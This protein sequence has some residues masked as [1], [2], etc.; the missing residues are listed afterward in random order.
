MTT[1]TALPAVAHPFDG[2]ADLLPLGVVAFAAG[3]R[4]AGSN[5]RA[6]DWFGALLMQ[7]EDRAGLAALLGPSAVDLLSLA[8]G[9]RA[10]VV[11]GPRLFEF[12][13]R[14]GPGGEYWLVQD[15]SEELRL[16][17]QLAEEGSLLAHVQEAFLV[18]DRHGV[19]RYANH[20]AER[21]RGAEAN[22]LVGRGLAELER[23]CGPTYQDPRAQTADE[24]RSRCDEVLRGR[25]SVRYHA[26]HRRL[27]GG[28]LPVE[29]V[30][31]PH[32]LSGET[33]VLISARD[34]GRRLMHLQALIQ[35]KDEA[36]TSNRAKSAF[37]A[38]T[39]H[40][41][42]TPLTGIIGFCELLQMEIAAA[43][44][45]IAESCLKHL[46]PITESSRSLLAIINDI[47]DLAK[48]E[49]R[50]MEV[51]PTSLDPER[52]LDITE[53]LWRERA[54]AKGLQLRRL[55]PA[56]QPMRIT[57]DGQ[58]VRQVLDN[59]LSN[60]LKFTERG[61]IEIGAAY[62]AE[63]VEYTIADTG[64]GVAEESR[65]RLFSAFWQAADH[66][67]RTAGGN[68]LGLYICRQLAELLGGKVWLERTSSAGSV[69][70]LRLPAVAS[71]TRRS[72]RVMKSG[73]WSVPPPR[74]LPGR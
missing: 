44:P 39:S 53:Q 51:R 58:R 36:E 55:P 33:V 37:L 43:P 49:A 64:C 71:D 50:Q 63:A 5:A 28:E 23:L 27:D 24:V 29:A 10:V 3:G 57:A 30:M 54:Q 52:L 59:L 21:E 1:A 19:V 12:S 67:T 13:V 42:R 17:A 32:R 62:T 61:R 68:G 66:H 72:G 65:P 20:H 4:I 56:G 6:R 46:R 40:E 73:T 7:A 35:A 60:A 11:L 69:F 25:G 18:V 22:G 2:L 8:D 38:I 34:D 9:G 15:V 48:I 47:C 31:R 70:R 74:D 14:S 26:L 16:R 41:L 45:A